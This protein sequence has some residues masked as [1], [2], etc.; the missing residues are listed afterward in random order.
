MRKIDFWA[1]TH[2]GLHRTNNED[3]FLWLTPEDTND[4]GYLW[5]VCDGMGGEA[6][7]ER[8]AAE[9][10]DR[11]QEVYVPTLARTG[12]PHHA[13]QETLQAANR[14]LLYLSKE[15]PALAGMGST[16]AA[17]AFYRERLWVATVGDSRV[18]GW[19]PHGLTQ[20][21][22][23][24]SKYEKLREHGVIRPEDERPDHPAR[25]VLMNVMGRESMYVDTLDDRHF[26]ADECAL[27][28]CTDGLSGNINPKEL[29][30]AFASL[31]A[32]DAARFLLSAALQRSTDNI[33]LQ[34][35]RFVPPVTPRTIEDVAESFGVTL[36]DVH[37]EPNLVES[38]EAL[39]AATPSASEAG[40]TQQ[41]EEPKKTITQKIE[42]PQHKGQTVLISPDALSNVFGDSQESAPP[43]AQTDEILQR[44]LSSQGGTVLLSPDALSKAVAEQA[45]ARPPTSQQ[46]TVLLSPDALS[47]AMAEQAGKGAPQKTTPEHARP[48]SRN[49][50]ISSAAIETLDPPKQ[51]E[52]PMDK[53]A[54]HEDAR[55]NTPNDGL[56]VN[57]DGRFQQSIDDAPPAERR[58]FIWLLIAIMIVGLAVVAWWWLRETPQKALPSE[59]DVEQQE[60]SDAQEAS[61]SDQEL[62]AF[63]YA[64]APET[65]DHVH[66]I[67]VMPAY[68]VA[69]G[70]WW[71][72]A[73]EVT[74]A[75]FDD[76]RAQ[77]ERAGEPADALVAW[78]CFGRDDSGAKSA[79]RP[80]C[81]SPA[82]AEL[83]CDAVGRRL[84]TQQEWNTIVDANKAWI[85]PG[86]GRIFETPEDGGPPAYPANAQGILG[87]YDGLPE[88][89]LPNDTQRAYG[90]IVLLAPDDT[91]LFRTD[92]SAAHGYH[93][94][95]APEERMIG[96]RC[97]VDAKHSDDVP[98]A[99]QLDDGAPQQTPP[100]TTPRIERPAERTSPETNTGRSGR[101][102]APRVDAPDEAP[103]DPNIPDRS[104]IL[105]Y[106]K[107]QQQ[108]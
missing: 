41:A 5:V 9:V 107:E 38:G 81:V 93:G 21:T 84:P 14:R 108:R 85:A 29:R 72:D 27:L 55:P 17:V 61:Q 42:L 95:T 6:A 20:W 16:V 87:V 52:L 33:T 50:G 37:N 76:V 99:L 7:G 44:R 35:I 54:P 90:D 40:A 86:Y 24:H 73:H 60:D 18:Y 22:V 34:V 30:V 51:T 83:Y 102:L 67:D 12:S 46:G 45:D 28:I 31:D 106:M 2:Q 68:L 97:I 53:A 15:D 26:A 103:I 75:Q 11:I 78:P 58:V 23:D 59:Q 32:Q 65:T 4:Q 69:D 92:A 62:G 8:A 101:S 64:A 79:R 91:Q 56:F 74:E 105:D 98:A 57:D 3:A 66:A 1:N 71:I 104:R 39:G 10:L 19:T 47:K 100:K 43:D 36:I 80:A 70:A 88:I 48:S 96:M 25:H 77:L 63:V 82:S 94:G 49:Q 13:L 89:L